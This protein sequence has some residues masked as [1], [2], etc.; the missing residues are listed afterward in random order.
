MDDL[1]AV[2][3]RG[4]SRQTGTL[5]PHATDP[6]LANV[7]ATEAERRLL[8]Q[9]G[10][11]A[12]GALAGKPTAQAGETP[13]AAP[14][15][16]LPAC[17]PRAAELLAM[18]LEPG[19]HELLGEALQLLASAGLRLPPA[20]LPRILERCAK[21]FHS[22]LGPVLGERGRWLCGFNPSWTRILVATGEELPANADELWSEGKLA[23]RKELLASCRR[24]DPARGSAWLASVWETENAEARNDLLAILETSLSDVDIP[25]LEQALAD[26]SKKVRVTAS[27]LLCRLPASAL[28]M[29]MRSLGESMLTYEPAASAGKLKSLVKS[30]TGSKAS[31][32]LVVTPPKQFDKAWEKLGLQEKAPQGTGQR[33]FWLRQVMERIPPTH[34][35]AHFKASPEEL[36]AAVAED[37]E[38]ATLVA[39]WSFAARQWKLPAWAAALW[40]A[41]KQRLGQNKKEQPTA[42]HWL[43]ELL[44]ALARDELDKRLCALLEA[45]DFGDHLTPHVCT[46]AE[47]PWSPALSTAYLAY[48]RRSIGN[49][50]TA[51][52]V[53]PQE[54]ATALAPA[55]FA[56][57]LQ[58]LDLPEDERCFR[59]AVEQFTEI[60]RLRQEFRQQVISQGPRS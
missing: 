43:R 32:K 50:Q 20:L 38:A 29:Q 19:H 26:G 15:D 21:D 41:W 12:I 40:D 8:L 18:F 33:A 14:P 60:I 13:P 36:I 34:W 22:L 45:G 9:A 44:P 55:S 3:L 54:A 35:E 1:V 10:V 51:H 16:R 53:F 49:P 42:G 57:A 30:L 11:R 17:S 37:D 52:Y 7:P 31:A 25:F 59:N 5:T 46:L 48:F 24:H 2:A 58:P 39:A 23:E 6:L 4:T 56:D 28:A 27:T 47:R